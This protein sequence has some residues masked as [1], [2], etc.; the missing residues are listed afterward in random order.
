M[1]PI[2]MVS[3]SGIL[4][5]AER[6]LIGCAAA[7][8]GEI[9]LA[10]PEGDVARE[11]RGEG[12]R[13]FPIRSRRLELRGSPRDR[14]LAGARLAEHSR[15]IRSL[16]RALD[17]ELVL[18]CGMRSAIA[19]SL[20]PGLGVATV[21]QHNDMLPGAQIARAT[22][23]AA[24]RFD[25][26]LVPSRAVAEDLSARAPMVVV[27][28]GVDVESFAPA[29]P[30]A[31][32]PE[33]IVL[34]AL[35]G[36]KRPDLALEAVAIARRARPNV[37]LRFVGAPLGGE[38]DGSALLARLRERASKPDLVEAVEFCGAVA[39]V[40]PALARATCLLHCAPREPFG[41]A[42]VEALAAARPAVVPAAAGPAEIVDEDC[43]VPYEPG[44]ATAAARALLSVLRDPERAQ[45]MGRRGQARARERFDVEVMRE[46]FVTA[47]T[48]FRRMRSP[49]AV[50]PSGIALV[51]VTYD[52]E[53]ELDALLRS[54][55]RHLP[56]TQV[57]VVDSAS[58][59]E[60]VAV[61][62]RGA[63]GVGVEVVALT[64]NVGFGRGCNIGLER[65]LAPVT[66]LVNPDV[67]LLDDSL[68]ALAAEAQRIDRPER[69]LAPLVVT[70]DGSRQDSV[71][72]LPTSL[73][74]L[75]RALI[76]PALIPGRAG[77]RL[78]PWRASSP[79]RVGWAV[80]CAIVARTET[81]RRLGPFDERIFMYGEDL[82]LGL[83]AA[84]TGVETWF[85][86]E[87]R[88][89]HHG[90]HSTRVAFGGE[91]FDLLARA[92]HDAVRRRLGGR[93]AR[94]DDRSQ[95][96]TF[97]SRTALKRLLGRDVER[98]RRQLEA[99]RRVRSTE[100]R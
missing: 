93:R 88:V 55:A 47:I 15:E 63:P 48:P 77:I 84:A 50:D 61:A 6:V 38:R 100:G 24:G 45:Q 10:C 64:D 5:G 91:A 86:P 68:L 56:G 26:V 76:P 33:V 98:E 18:A 80:G 58:S 95:A 83:A 70:P 96:V 12:I 49:R 54:V 52:S 44:D 37:L 4:G 66:A 74:D 89:L 14:V 8:E 67:E 31:Q 97:A 22:R 82:D 57:V 81:L 27:P 36:W 29:G 51:T 20:G 16:V 53:D 9:C 85:W 46:R 99:I 23:A 2:L 1:P 87:G 3:Y 59:D 21:F 34:G 30:P 35:V 13:V 39:D 90:A 11:A 40:R 25:L 7:L 94:I 65:V 62:R 28:P 71:H 43:G 19:L 42:V 75:S 92:R 79:R 78:A 32:P 69:L 73:A 60:T 72:P 41:L 17:P